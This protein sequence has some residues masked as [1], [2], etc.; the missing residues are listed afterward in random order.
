MKRVLSVITVVFVVAV[1]GACKKDPAAVPAPAPAPFPGSPTGGSS[2]TPPSVVSNVPPPAATVP[3]DQPI[4]SGN[5]PIASA[6]IETINRDSPLQAVFFAYDSDTIDEK[7][8][9]AMAN[10]AQVLRK[11][12]TWIV[13]IEGHCDERGTTEYNLALG[14][15]RAQAVKNYMVS[16]GI[17][18]DR[19]RTVSYGNE[20][21]FAPGHDESAWS[22]NRRA[23]FM[24]MA[25]Q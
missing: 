5:D 19:F 13:T 14:D 24:L 18:G 10:N 12:P 20:F 23:H 21:P 4:V 8:K 17:S 1:A 11:Y 7:A 25:K 2:S 9:A 3:V 22:L 16:L 15:R 6:S